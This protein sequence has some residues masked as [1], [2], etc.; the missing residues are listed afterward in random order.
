MACNPFMACSCC[1]ACFFDRPVARNTIPNV[2][3]RP[4]FAL[5]NSDIHFREMDNR[6]QPPEK[7]F[8][9]TSETNKYNFKQLNFI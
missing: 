2:T 4:F 6:F 9:T 3:V 5:F 8:G 1:F 7:L